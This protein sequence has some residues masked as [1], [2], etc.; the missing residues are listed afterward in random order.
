[1][2]ALKQIIPLLLPL[3]LALLVAAAGMASARG[4]FLYVLGRGQLLWRAF[5]AIC[6][7]P[8]LFAAAIVALFP[9]TP[10]ARAGIMLMALSPVPP[11]VIGKALKVGGAREYVYGIQVAASVFALF[12]V[13]L[14]G[15]L[16]AHFYEVRA[17]FPLAVVARNIAMGIV[18]PL[19]VG[20]L[21]GRWIMPT[22]AHRIAPAVSLIANIVLVIAFV[23]IVVVTWP[24]MTA[25]VG[26]GTL[27]A[28][29]IFVI[30]C[31]AGGHFLGA[32]GS[33]STLAFAS[34]T[35]HPG[36]ALALASANQSDKSVSAAVLL[37]VLVGL[38]ALLPY[39]MFVK[40][41]AAPDAEKAAKA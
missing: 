35:R 17:Q 26:N 39:Q 1:M 33:P 41:K 4:D 5:V 8:I 34:A 14:F 15:A 7:L 22:F 11:L 38:V 18:V 31:A 24:Q 2:E 30:C 21:L 32:P 37:I 28:I 19:V 9:L 16:V 36:I 12:T 20:L 23:P 27:L 25:L 29:V 13:P 3:S 6:V 40:R 10:A